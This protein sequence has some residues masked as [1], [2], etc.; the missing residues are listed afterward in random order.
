[1]RKDVLEYFY[2]TFGLQKYG[3]CREYKF[4]R[5]PYGIEEYN[6]ALKS[7]IDCRQYHL[8]TDSENNYVSWYEYYYP[9]FN[10]ER[11]IE[12]I[13]F[14]SKFEIILKDV[15]PLNI[16]EQVVFAFMYKFEESPNKEEFREF[17]RRVF[18]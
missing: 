2:E 10:Q 3:V 9:T 7:G 8:N 17:V 6:K 14:L 13:C 4:A 18:C 12:M 15:N 11:I 16:H 5:V 1:M